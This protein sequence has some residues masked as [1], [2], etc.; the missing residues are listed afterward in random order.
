MPNS[1]FAKRSA[2]VVTRKSQQRTTLRRSQRERR[3]VLVLLRMLHW[4]GEKK[5][6]VLILSC[7]LIVYLSYTRNYVFR[8]GSGVP[9]YMVLFIY[10]CIESAANDNRASTINHVSIRTATSDSSGVSSARIEALARCRHHWPDHRCE[11]YSQAFCPGVPQHQASPDR[12]PWPS[13]SRSS[14]PSRG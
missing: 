4:D 12:S 1:L 5:R 11:Q 7:C 9:V 13:Y 6:K 14:K 3:R 8:W 2:R 10:T